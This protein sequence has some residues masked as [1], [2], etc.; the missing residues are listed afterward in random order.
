MK[1]SWTCTALCLL[2]LGLLGCQR[3]LPLE[4]IWIAHLASLS[5]PHKAQGE[6]ARQ[7]IQLAVDDVNKEDPGLG[8]RR[9]GVLHVDIH[10]DQEALQAEAVR[11][12]K[13]NDAKALIGG[14]DAPEVASLGRVLPNY[15]VPLLT[16]SI[17]P[18]RLPAGLIYSLTVAPSFRGQ[19]LARF[20]SQE[21]KPKQ[22]VVL[23]D[24]SSGAHTTLT[25]AFTRELPKTE[26]QRVDTWSF[27]SDSE[28]TPLCDRLRESKPDVVLFAGSL[29]GLRKIRSKTTGQSGALIYAASDEILSELLRDREACQGLILAPVYVVDKEVAIGAEFAKRYQERFREPPGI[30]AGLAYDAIRLVAEAMRR[31]KLTPGTFIR[32]ELPK[33]ENFASLTGSLQIEKESGY[34]RRAVYVIKVEEGQEKLLKRY[35]PEKKAAN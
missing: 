22:I 21:L 29:A 8:G 4:P 27:A 23:V 12:I 24:G 13:V 11:V 15:G 5:G 9:I 14:A 30:A 28:L 34:A 20:V 17:L 16:P 1:P 18:D 33:V 25:E 7:A 10:D 3:K 26:G 6:Q 2:T 35:E 19:C 32:A 31:V